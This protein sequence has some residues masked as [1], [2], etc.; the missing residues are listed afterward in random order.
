MKD[1]KHAP[2]IEEEIIKKGT[3]GKAVVNAGKEREEYQATSFT[4]AGDRITPYEADEDL[5]E[6]GNMQE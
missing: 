4:P 2:E 1:E 3:R 6:K 5:A